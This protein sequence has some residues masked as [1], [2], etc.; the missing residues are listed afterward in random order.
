MGTR[1]RPLQILSGV[2]FGSIFFTMFVGAWT[3]PSQTAPAGNVS[4]PINVGSTDQVKNGNIGVNGLAV[5]G[6]SLLQGSAY[7]N[8]GATAGSAGYGI[9]DNAGILEFKNSGGS[10][11]SLQS[12]ICSLISC[13]TSVSFS[14]NKGGA[15]QAVPPGT[16]TKLTWSN[17][18]FDTGDRFTSDKFTPSVAGKYLFILNVACLGAGSADEC[19]AVISKNGTWIA[20]TDPGLHNSG[21]NQNVGVSIIADMNGTT[22]YVEGYIYETG[23]AVSGDT[24]NTNFSGARLSP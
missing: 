12:I 23:S 17:E 13:T 4:A 7:L 3:G 21:T 20:R 24:S 14:V 18:V 2:I 1:I 6:N 11:A 19:S 16:W 8:W 22:D 10:W 5:F 15:N 9:R